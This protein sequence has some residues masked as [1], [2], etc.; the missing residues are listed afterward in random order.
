MTD[1]NIIDTATTPI[2][3][4]VDIPSKKPSRL[5]TV[6]TIISLML[7]V[8]AISG[9]YYLYKINLSNNIV[10]KQ[11]TQQL[12][13][14]IETQSALQNEQFEESQ[15]ITDESKTKVEELNLQLLDIQN[16]NKLY[17][18]D[19]K[20]LQRSFAE[21]NVRHPND[22]ILSEIEYLINLS[23]RKLWLEHD[24]I[25]TIALL[26]AADQRVI[27][28]R[29]SSLNPLRRALLED[30]N[31]LSGLPKYDVDRAVLQLSSLERRINKLIISGLEVP[32]I[33]ENKSDQLS[34][35]VGDW[36]ENLRKSWHAFMESFII[37]SQRDVSVEA[38]LSPEQGWYLKENLR[39]NLAK[40]EFAIYREQQSVYD[41]A[42]ENALQLIEVY[43]D[44][45]D[46]G[47]QYFHSQIIELSQQKIMFTY[48]DQFKS[49]SL[50]ARIIE[51]RLTKSLII[52]EAE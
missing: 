9:A 10:Y 34:G 30:I 28:M 12:V 26:K 37:I 49:A 14:K 11:Q 3:P 50:L 33:E 13:S 46:R 38:L 23:S 16:K 4:V 8:C 48:P 24:L 41:L 7:S 19:V 25:S 22:W 32:A 6:I 21:K 51:Q 31:M 43:F 42:L 44:M 1:N 36:K 15:S 5:L 40:A 45:T 29:D 52:D 17:S 27:E 39:N 18:S 47:N 2:E 20:S 35:N